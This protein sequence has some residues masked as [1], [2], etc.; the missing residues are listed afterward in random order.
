MADETYRFKVGDI[1]CLAV[2]DGSH[3]YVPPNFPP[4]ATLLFANAPAE[5]KGFTHVSA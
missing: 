3:T 2:S 5:C 1:Q 4:P